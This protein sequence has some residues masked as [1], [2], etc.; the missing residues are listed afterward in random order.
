MRN[1]QAQRYARWSATAAFLLAVIV[2]GVYLRG[3]WVAKQAAK[4]A[5][6]AVPAAV[7]Q[8]SNEFSYS[9]VEGQR[10]IYTVQASRTT[11]FKEGNRNL[12]EDV[13]ISVFGKRGERNDTLRTKACDFISSTG[14]ITCAGEVQIILQ[15]GG[16]VGASAKPI[17]VLTSGVS[18][19]R[20]SGVARTDKSVTFRWPAGEG[21]AVGVQ[22]DS[23]Q[24]TL[25]L[26]HNVELSLAPAT[27]KSGSPA[28]S[29]A[30]PGPVAPGKAVQVTGD[31][32]V[33]HREQR[34]VQLL[35]SVHAVQTTHELTGDS[36]LL[37]L[38]AA[39]HVKHLTA[40]GH[41]R[42]TDTDV[43]SPMTLDADEI[44]AAVTTEGAVE[45]IV[46]TG[47]VHGSRKFAAGE[48]GIEAGR[49]QVNLVTRQNVP[50]LLTAS[51]KVVLTSSSSNARGGTRR[52]ESES[53]EIHF[54]KDSVPGHVLVETVNT[55]APARVEW[56]DI[57]ML[58]GKP[59]KQ[60]TRMRGNRM[61]LKFAGQNELD[62]LTGT[63]GV[64]VTRQL[65]DAPEQTTASRELAAKF[66]NSGEWSTIDQ[67][68]DVRFHEGMRTGQGDRAHADHAAN[69]VALSGSVVLSDGTMRTTAQ[70]ALFTQDS[71]ELRADGN[72]QSI[73]L[74]A[75][76]G[77]PA[78]LAA[79][80]AHVSAAH[81][82]ADVA[83]G[84][85]IYS[86]GSRLWQGD[87]VI[88][89]DTVE[90]DN[91]LH[92]LVARGH[93]RGV[94]PQAAWNPKGGP[95]TGQVAHQG[96]DLWHVRGGL[97]TYWGQE[98]R[99][100]IEQ[101]PSA[102]S[103]E[104]SI[105]AK[106]IDLFFAP[107]PAGSS[108]QQ[109]TRVVATED[110]TVR[111]EDRRGTSN[112]AEYTASEGKFVLSEGKPTLYDSNGDRTTGRQLTFFFSDD[113]IVVDSEEGL[114]TL[115]LHRVEK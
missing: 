74:H 38:D 69:T 17:R 87:S 113:R 20:D 55:L 70:S 61:D 112:K 110:V 15:A 22:Y 79:G 99:A 33:F 42:M 50:R 3:V 26:E 102:D 115:T 60:T 81:L 59:G 16:A 93:V 97:L 10:T 21:R 4:K 30:G 39:F 19:D 18:F 46:A 41:P 27:P 73:E 58:N 65:G 25:H 94:F 45:S 48:D 57:A 62:R 52:V 108:A 107:G 67:T 66:S 34:T 24:G 96:T 14:K 90:L 2:C 53:L 82:V 109:L 40:S 86:G 72:V 51:G 104:G 47:N 75:G 37:D 54:T 106:L 105:H 78:N 88:E 36:L 32:M 95:P 44:S 111:E 43:Q 56:Q 13:S 114:R 92:V 11:E 1:S 77:S 64:E 5:P 103:A 76:A 31:S 7:E 91:P 9:K 80:P 84:H 83:K 89:A 49:V 100:R 71:N 63:G 12:L 68:G 35:G 8:R 98:S 85:A 101:D 29:V 23:N 6:P 28:E